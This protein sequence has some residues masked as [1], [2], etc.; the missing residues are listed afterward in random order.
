LGGD[1][2]RQ[3]LLREVD[4]VLDGHG[5]RL[6]GVAVWHLA[7]EMLLVEVHGV[8][9]ALELRHEGRRRLVHLLPMAARR[10]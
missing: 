9:D 7:R 4:Q 5:R 3:R 8:V 10:T 6:G 1:L 2:G